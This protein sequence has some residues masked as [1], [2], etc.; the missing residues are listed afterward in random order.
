MTRAEEALV[1]RMWIDWAD[2]KTITNS[3]CSDFFFTLI[4][5]EPGLRHLNAF[6]VLDTIV[7][8]ELP[9]AAA[10]PTEQTEPA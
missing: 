10:T 9:T 5:P 4:R 3:V 6:E 2:G 8:T 7:N 1:S